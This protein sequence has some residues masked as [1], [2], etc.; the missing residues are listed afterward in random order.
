MWWVVHSAFYHAS[1]FPIEERQVDD[2]LGR[3]FC[4]G[5]VGMWVIWGGTLCDA[6]WVL[7]QVGLKS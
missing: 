5:I 3:V 2:I 6:Y 4:K 1:M 7:F